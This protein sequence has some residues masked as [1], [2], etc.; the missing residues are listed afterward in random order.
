DPN[1]LQPGDVLFIPPRQEKQ[2][3]GQTEMR[4]RFR[5]RGTPSRLR[6]RLLQDGRPRAHLP[7]VV[8]VDGRL[9]EGQTDADGW[10]E[11]SIPPNARAGRL[12]VGRGAEVYP[13][14]LGHIDPTE[15][16][17][18]VQQ[19]LRNLGLYGGPVDGQMNDQTRSAIA[20]FQ[21]QRNL[22]V[23]GEPDQ[24]TRDALRDAHAS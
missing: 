6:I 20:A 4:H 7:Y 16:L 24:A 13:F 12:L 9:I 22:E 14:Q 17:A 2:E 23:T 15:G 10:L 18:G 1:V 21:A 11:Q 19:R 3:S 8:E 5:R